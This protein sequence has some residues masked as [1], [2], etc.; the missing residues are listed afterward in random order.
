MK[1]NTEI[2]NNELLTQPTDVNACQKIVHL[3][4]KCFNIGFKVG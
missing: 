3:G 1:I 2:S 4:Q